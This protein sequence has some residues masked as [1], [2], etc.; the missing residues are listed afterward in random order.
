MRRLGTRRSVG[1]AEV[2]GDHREQPALG[3]REVLGVRAEAALHVA[4]DPVADLE[5]ADRGADD[6]CHLTGELGAEDGR[7]RPQEP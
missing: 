4:E 5:G 7:A 3:D 1:I 6:G 2:L